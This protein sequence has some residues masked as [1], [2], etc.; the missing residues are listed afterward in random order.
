MV[1]TQKIFESFGWDQGSWIQK[2]TELCEAF[3]VWHQYINTGFKMKL[4]WSQLNI[5][6]VLKIKTDR[7]TPSS[8]NSSPLFEIEFHFQDLLMS[9]SYLGYIPEETG[10]RWKT[11]QNVV[12]LKACSLSCFQI[13]VGTELS[14]SIQKWYHYILIK[15]LVP[16]SRQSASGKKNPK[17]KTKP[18]PHQK[19]N[20]INNKNLKGNKMLQT[21]ERLS[22]SSSDKWAGIW[23]IIQILFIF[24]SAI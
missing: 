19:Q 14:T 23:L 1:S 3:T 21:I 12:T 17:T 15:N 16:I 13:I 18:K 8:V 4:Y 24:F 22:R 20:S 7:N 11:R 6:W 9:L 10:E 5:T 2:I